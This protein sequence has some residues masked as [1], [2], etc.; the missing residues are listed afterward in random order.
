[1]KTKP[2][3]GMIKQLLSSL[4]ARSRYF[5]QARPTAVNYFTKELDRPFMEIKKP[6]NA[7]L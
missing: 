5:A 4:I 1:M 2:G 3:D 7:I 6:S